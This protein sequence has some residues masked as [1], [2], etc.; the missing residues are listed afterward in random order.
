MSVDHN[1]DRQQLID[2]AHPTK[3]AAKSKH[4]PSCGLPRISG[5]GVLLLTGVADAT[6]S[7]R[8]MNRFVPPLLARHHAHHPRIHGLPVVMN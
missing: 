1:W 5:G 6:F 4:L 7:E 8:V 3:Q 2:Q